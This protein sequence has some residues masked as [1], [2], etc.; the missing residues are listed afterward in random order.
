MSQLAQFVHAQ[1]YDMATQ[2]RP[3]GVPL[4]GSWEGWSLP[5]IHMLSFAGL[6]VIALYTLVPEGQPRNRLKW[7]VAVVVA[8][9][10]W[11]ASTS[12]S[13]RPSAIVIGVLIG[14]SFAR[15]PPSASSRRA[16]SSR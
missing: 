1:L 7:V 14:V 8:S 13:T 11:P 9:S 16:K 12:A 15:R 5:S 6:S 4:R 2:P 10:R 3:F